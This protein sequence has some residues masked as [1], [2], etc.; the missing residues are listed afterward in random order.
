MRTHW[1]TG[2]NGKKK[3]F[4]TP[5]KLKKRNK[6]KAPWAFPLAERKINLSPYPSKTC[7]DSAV[8]TPNSS[9]Q[10]VCQ[11][12]LPGLKPLTKNTPLISVRRGGFGQNIWVWNPMLL[13]TPLGNTLRTWGTIWEHGRN[14]SATPKTKKRKLC[15]LPKTEGSILEVYSS[16]PLAQLYRWKEDYMCQSIWDKNEVLWRT[17]WGTYWEHVGTHWEF[18]GNIVGTHWEPRKNEKNS[19]PPPAPQSPLKT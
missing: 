8:S 3:S 16:S 13:G 2:K 18:K 19:L 6:N 15:R 1:E 14:T 10:T 9:S 5:P 7:M 12:N 11:K 17:C 4:T